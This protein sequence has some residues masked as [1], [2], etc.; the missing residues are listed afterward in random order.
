MSSFCLTC[1]SFLL[2]PPIC[3]PSLQSCHLRREGASGGGRGL[4]SR[5]PWTFKDSGKGGFFM[6]GRALPP[7]AYVTGFVP[8]TGGCPLPLLRCQGGGY[9][10]PTQGPHRAWGPPA[11]E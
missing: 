7:S 9:L 3:F 2:P 11:P 1:P 10:Y 4:Y 8:S 6:G 5:V